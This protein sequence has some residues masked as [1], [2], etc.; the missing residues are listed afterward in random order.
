MRRHEQRARELMLT[1]ADAR[2][3]ITLYE[4]WDDFGGCPACRTP[5]DGYETTIM[6]HVRTC[7]ALI[8]ATQ[9]EQVPCVYC[10]TVCSTHPDAG[11]PLTY[12]GDCGRVACPDHRVEDAADRCVECAA[13]HYRTETAIAVH[14]Q[15]KRAGWN[16]DATRAMRSGARRRS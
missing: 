7:H 8:A 16:A 5:L 10:G 4:H 1:A 14:E 15:V 9:Y 3:Y 2:A 12:C 6:R 13:L 11:S